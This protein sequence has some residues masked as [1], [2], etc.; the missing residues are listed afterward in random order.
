L[1]VRAKVT[2]VALT[3]LCMSRWYQWHHV[4]PSQISALRTVL[5]TI[6]KDIR[7][8]WLHSGVTYTTIICT[9]LSL[10]LLC[11]AQQ[12]Y[13]QRCNMHSGVMDTAMICTIAHHC[14]WHHCANN[15]LEYLRE[16]EATF[17]KAL[18]RAS[19]PQGK[20]FHEKNHG[21][22]ISCQGPFKYL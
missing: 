6:S 1:N 4:H 16:F 2:A 10:T 11:H 22:K 21:S 5:R 9:A 19:G 12:Y 8:S 13:W 7:Q 17:E 3:L 14:R 15:F 18:T 20:L